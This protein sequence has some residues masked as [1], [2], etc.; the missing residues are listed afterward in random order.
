MRSKQAL[1]LMAALSTLMSVSAEHGVTVRDA[2]SLRKAADHNRLLPGEC[3]QTLYADDAQHWVQVYTDLLAFNLEMLEGI[4]R[5]VG[6][7]APNDGPERSDFELIKA[8]VRRLRWRRR[9]WE[10]RSAALSRATQ[11]PPATYVGG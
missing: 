6:P 7:S 4:G 1:T 5:R 2:A 9:F 8:H 11:T 3:P 10:R